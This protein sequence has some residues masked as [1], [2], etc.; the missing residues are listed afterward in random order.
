MV[1]PRVVFFPLS[2]WYTCN[3]VIERRVITYPIGAKNRKSLAEGPKSA[4][5]KYTK[6]VGNMVYELEVKPRCIYFERISDKGERPH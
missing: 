3:K 4:E 6:V 5:D 1:L 2:K